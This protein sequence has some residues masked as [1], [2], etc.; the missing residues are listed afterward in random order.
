MGIKN[1]FRIGKTKPT[2]SKLTSSKKTQ[3]KDL[4]TEINDLISTGISHIDD[5]L[6]LF[7]VNPK[8]AATVEDVIGPVL[9]ALL[10][11][12]TS[13]LFDE[14]NAEREVTGTTKFT[15]EIS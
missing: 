10:F 15:V 9:Q 8:S 13:V 12:A 1:I 14:N 2:S 4:H 11:Q 6:I 7:G 3:S 5:L